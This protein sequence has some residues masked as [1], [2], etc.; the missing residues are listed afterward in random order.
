MIKPSE[1]LWDV[2]LKESVNKRIIVS[3]MIECKSLISPQPW[4]SD[5][6]KWPQTLT[7]CGRQKQT[8]FL[9]NR[10]IT[11]AGAIRAILTSGS[12]TS[13]HLGLCHTD[14]DKY[15]SQPIMPVRILQGQGLHFSRTGNVSE[16]MG[17]E[18]YPGY[19]NPSWNLN[20]SWGEKMSIKYV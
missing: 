12:S 5:L 2:K 4:V 16:F 20:F 18:W 10:R 13:A 1:D 8:S 11:D 6:Q 15:T 17:N 3:N 7:S 14:S 19:K 9:R